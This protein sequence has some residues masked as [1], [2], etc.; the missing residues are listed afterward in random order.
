MIG[1]AAVLVTVAAPPDPPADLQPW[2]DYAREV[3]R[4]GPACPPGQECV[5]LQRVELRGRA[6][7]GAVVMTWH[8]ANL[9][10]EA[11]SKTVIEPARAFAVTGAR[12]R[13]GR[14]AVS[15][16]GDSWV[17]QIRPGAFVVELFVAFEPAASVPMRLGGP[18]ANI[19]DRLDAG[20]VAFDESSDRHGGV[21][22]L[23]SEARPTRGAPELSVR[24]TR[25]FE[26][27]SVVTFSYHFTVTGLRE[28]ARVQLPRLGGETFEGI[29]PDIPYSVTPEAIEVTLTPGRTTVQASGHFA[30]APAEL[31]KP[32][33]LSFEYWLFDSDQRHPARLATD[34]V[35]IDPGEVT[36]LAPGPR[37]RAYFLVEDQRL[38]VPP[39]EVSLDKGRQGAGTATVRYAQG[40]G[41]HW[42]GSVVLTSTTAPESDRITVPTPAA[43][44]YAAS[45][46][47]AVRM[48]GDGGTLSLRVLADDDRLEP[49]RVQ[50]R[51]A[52]G[53]NAFFSLPALRVPGQRLHLDDQS[54]DVQLQPGYVP[55]AVFGAEHARGHLVDGLH[56]YAV[57]IA[58][59]GVA[60]ARTGRFPLWALIVTAILLAGLYTV[61]GFPRVALL[62]LLAGCAILVRLPDK[63][64]DTVR[65]HPVLHGFLSLIWITIL[66][67]TLIPSVVYIK[68]RIYSALHPWSAETGAYADTDI[69]GATALAEPEAVAG[70]QGSDEPWAREELA[71]K[72]AQDDLL[73]L[74]RSSRQRVQRLVKKRTIPRA[75]E[76]TIRPVAFDKPGLPARSLSYS[77]GSLLPGEEVSARIVLAGP[78]L[79]GVWMVAE[80]VGL[81]AVLALLVI[82]AR[83]WWVQ[84]VQS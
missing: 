82:R 16:S 17:L 51:E 3:T 80:C 19:V 62:V 15:M 63:A 47:E 68:D 9:G 5:Q 81:S 56:I 28:Q 2:V 29:E 1:L 54:V 52:V 32:A 65:A 58:L 11:A 12:W 44:H 75:T 6:D 42:V 67:V 64:L 34:G 57:L 69:A 26:Y 20:T 40:R 31:V 18:V 39:L 24:A 21:M 55:V 38:S 22:F 60:F 83:R 37:S 74:S 72:A 33:R 10:T 43:P 25:S 78:I 76:K 4:P 27:G 53:A 13:T 59:L 84:G 50:W 45:G 73:E 14:G 30:V 61:D 41:G 48:F 71:G 8:G 7:R 77:F 49:I 70:G 35:E 79:R 66:L 36:G 23:E 46:G